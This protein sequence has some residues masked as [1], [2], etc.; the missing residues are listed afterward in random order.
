M[1]HRLL[2]PPLLLS[3]QPESVAAFHRLLVA[4][5]RFQ[6]PFLRAAHL[7][8]TTRLLFKATLRIL[9]LL[10]HDFPEYLCEHHQAL[11]D[12]IPT[13]C[14]QMRNLVL[15]AYPRALQLPDPF[16]PSVRLAQLPEAAQEPVVRFDFRAVFAA[17]PGLQDAL[18]EFGARRGAPT[19][20]TSLREALTQPPRAGG[21]AD[22][23]PRYNVPLVNAV[24][25]YVGCAALESPQNLS[26]IHI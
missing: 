4:L 24:V 3:K 9:L 23:E 7:Q 16:A 18:D 25:L 1:S 10:L 12:A 17:R 5:L 8:D 26:L 20:L 6:A 11:C 13:S 14:I 21:P 19:F 2:M 15:C 22:A